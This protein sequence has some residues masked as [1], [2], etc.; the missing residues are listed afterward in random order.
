[1]NLEIASRLVK[2][3]KEKGL[4]QEELADK[5]GISRQ[6]VSKWERAEASPDTDNLILLARL[7]D[8]SLD[9]LLTTD[10]KDD[11]FKPEVTDV[12][13]IEQEVKMEEKEESHSL[14][15]TIFR[16]I[17]VLLVVI[18]YL[19]LGFLIPHEGFAKGWLLFL[20]IPLAFSL[21]LAI[22]K[23]N[24]NIFAYPVL[25]VIIFLS[26]GFFAG[27]WHPTWIVF[28]TIPVYYSI[29]GIIYKSKKK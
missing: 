17:Y 2:L 22:E 12:S 6:A 3:R 15:L 28:V 1:M 16:S 23:R 10:A 14:P 7:Y 18:T 21:F 19:L 5:L 9:S 25:A 26:V 27:I 29:T 11:E 8:I 24:A 13:D 20:T 4:S